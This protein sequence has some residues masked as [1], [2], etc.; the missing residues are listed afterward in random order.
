MRIRPA[1]VCV[2]P[3]R[4][5]P[6]RRLGASRRFHAARPRYALGTAPLFES[7]IYR[8]RNS[9]SHYNTMEYSCKMQ[10]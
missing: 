9:I 1:L 8:L 4:S 7:L 6:P 10:V 5:G 2:L 3:T